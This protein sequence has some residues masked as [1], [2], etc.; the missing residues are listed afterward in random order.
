MAE[1][2]VAVA[3][4]GAVSAV[5]VAAIGLV[6]NLASTRR[7]P[8]ADSKPPGAGVDMTGVVTVLAAQLAETEAALTDVTKRAVACEAR[9]TLRT[10]AD[11]ARR[12][13]R[14]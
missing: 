14:T 11:R 7:K 3:A 1:P 8:D 9:E 13:R 6:G 4:I 12:G 10:T 2:L 5:T